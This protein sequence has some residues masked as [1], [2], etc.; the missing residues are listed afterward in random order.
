MSVNIKNAHVKNLH[1]GP[2]IITNGLVSWWN[3]AS[4]RSY[5]RTGS[6]WY[7][8]IKK[9]KN[10]GSLVNMSETN[11]SEEA[12]GVLVFDGANE[13]VNIPNHTSLNFGTGS[14]TV[15]MWVRLGNFLSWASAGSYIIGKR[16][17]GTLGSY[18]GWQIKAINQYGLGWDLVDSGI[19]D[20]TTSYVAGT[21]SV[22]SF[23]KWYM[24]S[25][26]YDSV[27]RRMG[28]WIDK[29]RRAVR[30]SVTIDTIDN[31]LPV[32]IMGT[33]YLNGAQ[34]SSPVEATA[35]S[36][37]NVAVYTRAL[38]EEEITQNYQVRLSMYNN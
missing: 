2:R 1:I 6:I 27:Q 21:N 12:G 26:T 29:T 38:S 10:D 36:V 4:V 33:R 31:I 35:G 23:D 16:G 7:D 37:S 18:A 9:N 28:L 17:L 13:Y 34:Y 14:F 22:F 30:N 32:E 11:F 24:I 15:S 25:I 8:L 3:A 19:D 20:G 5:P